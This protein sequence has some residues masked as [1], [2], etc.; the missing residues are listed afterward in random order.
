[1]TYRL[2]Y[3]P[4]GRQ[5]GEAIEA[6]SERAAKVRFTKRHGYV[7]WDLHAVVTVA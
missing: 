4:T 2:I 1:M 7:N 6:K 3:L 5:M